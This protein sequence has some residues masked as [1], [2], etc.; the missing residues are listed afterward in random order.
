MTTASGFASHSD[1]HGTIANGQSMHAQGTFNTPD[2]TWPEWI[3]NTSYEVGDKVTYDKHGYI[4]TTANSD[5]KFT[6]S[7]WSAQCKNGDIAFVIGNGTDS[8]A[9]SNALTVNWD[10]TQKIA[11]DLYTNYNFDTN[12]GNK[13]A[14]EAYVT[15][16]IAGAGG[17]DDYALKTDT[18]L[19][20]TLSM[21][22]KAE[23]VVG[24]KSVALGKDVTASGKL[25]FA[26]GNMTTASGAQ[27]HAE[28]G[29]TTASAPQSHAEGGGS[30]ATGYS[31]H[32]EG[33]ATTASGQSSHA[34][35]SSTQATA[36]DAHAEGGSSQATGYAAHAEGQGT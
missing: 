3:E 25:S 19:N 28:G 36:G 13:V 21:G 35:G 23:T 6:D 18:V 8:T 17:G 10:G 32:A 24:E 5:A 31:A 16:A 29:G 27:S 12:T 20:T 14:T 9:R 26:T 4:C 22:R 1:G 33:Q 2:E 11:G 34:E 30:Q 7:N 15:E